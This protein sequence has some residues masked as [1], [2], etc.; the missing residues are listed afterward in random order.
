MTKRI[1]DLNADHEV[2]DGLQDAR[3]ERR[4]GAQLRRI[5]ALLLLYRYRATFRFVECRHLAQHLRAHRQDEREPVI[6]LH[7]ADRDA[8]QIAA[9]VENAAAG[10]ARMTVS[11][12]R[13]EAV[14]RPLS[15]VTGRED[16]PFRIIVAATAAALGTLVAARR[17]D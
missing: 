6:T 4:C 2:P 10:H 13:H 9:L 14:G 12:A 3:F 16:D 15:N 11:Q 5:P 17:V 1:K 8:D 7:P